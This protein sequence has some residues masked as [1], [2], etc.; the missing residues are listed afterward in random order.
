ME[1]NPDNPET[2]T[3]EESHTIAGMRLGVVAVTTPDLDRF[4]KFYELALG[5]RM[6]VQDTPPQPDLT[7]LGVFAADD[8]PLLLAFEC[9]D[10]EV[11]DPSPLGRRGAIDHFDLAV[12][13]PA[14]FEVVRQRLVDAGATAGDVCKIGPTY[15]VVFVD[16]DGRTARLVRPR[17]NWS[18]DTAIL[19]DDEFK[20]EQA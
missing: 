9:P 7:R 14:T 12:D 5:L 17:H 8:Q 16:P 2:E 15:S 19:L 6:V 10:A 11:T 3:H 1:T 20:T 13:D 4:R 18:S